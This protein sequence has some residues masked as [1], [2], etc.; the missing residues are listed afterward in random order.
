[1]HVKYNLRVLIVTIII[2]GILSEL[3]ETFILGIKKNL[4]KIQTEKLKMA[5]RVS[6]IQASMLM[7]NHI[8]FDSI[9]YDNISQH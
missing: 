1:M 9:L 3:P 6:I 5:V 8:L 2:S 7:E 4:R